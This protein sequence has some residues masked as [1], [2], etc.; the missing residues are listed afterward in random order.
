VKN[1]KAGEEKDTFCE[2]NKDKVYQV[3][4]N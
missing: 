1:R 4:E 2:K 3:K